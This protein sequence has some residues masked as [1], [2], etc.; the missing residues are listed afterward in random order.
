MGGGRGG[1]VWRGGGWGGRLAPAFSSEHFPQIL[2]FTIIIF[3]KFFLTVGEKPAFFDKP[4]VN[5]GESGRR[6]GGVRKPGQGE[7]THTWKV[8]T[9]S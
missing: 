3:L 9:G 8:F 4:F 1:G 7:G 6:W 5:G 2:N